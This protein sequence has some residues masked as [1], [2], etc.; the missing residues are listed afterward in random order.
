MLGHKSDTGGNWAVLWPS[1][2]LLLLILVLLLP[3]IGDSKYLLPIK[4]LISI[5]VVKFSSIFFSSD[6]VSVRV[7]CVNGYLSS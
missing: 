5:N 6:L 3:F 1:M 7:R 4:K 2:C